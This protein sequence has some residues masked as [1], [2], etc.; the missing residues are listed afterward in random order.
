[1]LVSMCAHTPI[2]T[3]TYIYIY[4]YIYIH[5]YTYIYIYIHTTCAVEDV[6]KHCLLLLLLLL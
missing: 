1:M 4:I 3:C 6:V 5:M 2:R